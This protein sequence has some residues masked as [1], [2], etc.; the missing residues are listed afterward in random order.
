MTAFLYTG[1]DP[2]DPP[3]MTPFAFDVVDIGRKHVDRIESLASEQPALPDPAMGMRHLILRQ[4]V[5]RRKQRTGS[6]GG[7]LPYFLGRQWSQVDSD[8]VDET[9]RLELAGDVGILSDPQRH[10]IYDGL[11]IDRGQHAELAPARQQARIGG[12]CIA[13]ARC[14]DKLPRPRGVPHGLF[15]AVLLAS[16]SRLLEGLLDKAVR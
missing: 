7:L 8:L 1:L 15:G 12:D 10:A 3:A 4:I 2:R 6:V 11:D 9:L 16:T 13:E 14:S 5:R